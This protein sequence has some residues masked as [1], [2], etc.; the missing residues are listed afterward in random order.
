MENSCAWTGTQ[1]VFRQQHLKGNAVFSYETTAAC[2]I[3]ILSYKESQTVRY[4][5]AD[6][7]YRLPEGY[8]VLHY[9][10]MGSKIAIHSEDPCNHLVVVLITPES[11]PFF[12]DQYQ[13]E[14]ERFAKGYTTASDTRFRLL[15]DQLLELPETDMLYRMRA[16]LLILEMLLYQIQTLAE[17]NETVPQKVAVKDHYE[18]V[19]RVK[20]IIEEDL[21]KNHS[22]PELAKQVGT[23][24]QYL[25]KYFKQYFGKTVL[26]YAIEKK[27]AY[28]K[29]LILTG[30]YLVSDVARMTGYKHATHFTTAFK[31]HFGFIPNSLRYSL[32]LQL[33][34]EVWVV[35]EQAMQISTLQMLL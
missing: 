10:E 31:K 28:A 24:V 4:S 22:I 3:N 29:E 13:Q 33:A 18:K 16:D 20:A 7:A 26:N 27:M 17:Q 12:H 21:S 14:T 1:Y 8:H 25:K 34:T 19:L 9:L 11:L 23:N 2:Y 32:L 30:N 6:K 15:L 35:L 5:L